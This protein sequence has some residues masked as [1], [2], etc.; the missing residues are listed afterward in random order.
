MASPS[1]SPARLEVNRAMFLAELARVAKILGRRKEGDALLSYRDGELKLRVGGAECVI[2]PKG[3][4]KAK[5]ACL[6]PGSRPSAKSRRP[7][8]RS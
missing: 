6:I 8:I 4:G 3:V 1:D 2:L 5:R 7:G